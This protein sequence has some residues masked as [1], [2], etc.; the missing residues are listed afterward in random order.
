LEEK[1]VFVP[2]H[3]HLTNKKP[4]LSCKNRPIRAAKAKG[5]DIK[6]KMG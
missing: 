1:E 4:G 3:E 5:I 6:F 2:P